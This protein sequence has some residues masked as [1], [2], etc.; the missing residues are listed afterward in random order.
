MAA[1]V[2]N[3]EGVIGDCDKAIA[4]GSRTVEIDPRALRTLAVLASQRR[5]I[6]DALGVYHKEHPQLA[7]H[8]PIGAVQFLLGW[9]IRSVTPERAGEPKYYPSPAWKLMRIVRSPSSS[10]HGMIVKVMH[11]PI[12]G[13]F[14]MVDWVGRSVCFHISRQDSADWQFEEAVDP[15]ASEPAAPEVASPDPA[16]A[17]SSDETPVSTT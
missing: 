9:Y 6:S 2:L 15:A 17:P 10:M 4:N 7:A 5:K 1:V 14:A 11:P 12:P 16:L 13:V 3:P 8:D